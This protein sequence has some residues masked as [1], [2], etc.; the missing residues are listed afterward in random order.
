MRL[1]GDYKK[2][3]ILYML[4]NKGRFHLYSDTSEFATESTLYLIQNDKPK[5]IAYVS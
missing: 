2:P 3:P 5:L 4:D 1:T